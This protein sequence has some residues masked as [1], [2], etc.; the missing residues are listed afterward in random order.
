VVA[1]DDTTPGEFRLFLEELCCELCRFRHVREDGL[2]AERVATVRDTRIGR[3]GTFADI[4]VIPADRSPYFVE[5]KWGYTE[6]DLIRR[7]VDKYA[8]DLDG[9][10]QKLIVVTDLAH[11]PGWPAIAKKLRAGLSPSLE[12]EVW[13]ERELLRQI[14]EFLGLT[15]DRLRG[16]NYQAIRDSIVR[17]EWTRIFGDTADDRL[18]PTLLW[19]F[20]P[21]T[22]KHLHRDLGLPPHGILRPGVHRDVAVLM[23]DL[24]SFS[25]YVR[26][27]RDDALVRQ[28]LTTFYSQA[29]HA[30]L[31]SG[32]ML[33]KFVGDQVIGLFGFPDQRPG[34]ADEAVRCA[35][36]LV[37]IGD[38]VSERW[39]RHLD[40]AQESKGVHIGVAMGD[41]SLMPLR[42]F[43]T[44]HFAFIGDAI[45]M[46]ARLMEAAAP[47][48]IVISNSFY[49]ALDPETQRAFLEMSPVE[50]KG[51]G[52]IMCWR[53]SAAA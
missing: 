39:Q 13:G 53:V 52:L 24:C 40:R 18:A 31:D 26:D 51:A 25:S 32:G 45:N 43:S 7:L 23:A 2:P 27:T 16:A 38:S 28:A 34:Y 19:H 20:S 12:L 8:A 22:L 30:I 42:A 10:R 41:L 5:I 21:W 6:D 4:K 35:R 48:E 49:R 33:D 14:K 44:A 1:E 29:R 9:R 17:A 50:G 46:A 3:T 36:R 37:D 11:Q 15:I 47:S